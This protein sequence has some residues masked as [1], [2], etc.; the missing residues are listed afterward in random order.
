MFKNAS[1]VI[2]LLPCDNGIENLSNKPQRD[3][4]ETTSEPKET[5]QHKKMEARC[6]ISKKT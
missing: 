5:P 4:L 6:N 3:V 1:I 2:H